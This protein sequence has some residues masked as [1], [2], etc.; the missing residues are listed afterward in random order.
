MS[1]PGGPIRAMSR[2]A[3]IRSVANR[4]AALV[5]PRW[6]AFWH[7]LA[8]T[9]ILALAFWSFIG[10]FTLVTFRSHGISNDEE[11]QHVYGRLLLSFYSSGFTDLSAFTYKNLYLYG[12]LFD[13]FAA[14]IEKVAPFGFWEARHL[15]S[16]CFGIAGMAGAYRIARQIGGEKAGMLAALLLAVTGSWIGAMF[17][18]TK[19]VPF[20]ACMTW[21]L[22]YSMRVAETLPAPPLRLV[23]KLGLT[24]GM[25]IGL[26]VGAV[27]AAFYMALLVGAA[28][29][30][31][32]LSW[33]E[34]IVFVR[35][36]LI[37]LMPAA[38]LAFILMAFFWPWSVMAPTNLFTALTA[39]SHFSFD[40]YTIVDGVV[41]K[42]GDVPS[43]YL[44]QYLLVRLPELLLL[45]V[46]AAAVL[47]PAMLFKLR[48][49]EPADRR[50]A[51]RVIGLLLAIGVPIGFTLAKAPPLYNGIRH[52]LFVVP[53]LAVAAAL[54]LRLLWR[55][56]WQVQFGPVIALALCGGLAL[57]H[58]V[59]MVRLHP[60]QYV[61]Y[62][63]L[64]GGGLEGARGKWELDYWSD[65]IRE[66]AV[67]LNNLVKA[68]GRTVRHPYTVAVCAE[69]L[70]AATYLSPQ[71]RVTA[72]W[73]NADFFISS[74]HMDCHKVL[75][76]DVV[77]RVKREDVTLAVVR[78]RRTLLPL[79]R[80]PRR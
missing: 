18:H 80:P 28:A 12:G 31:A 72:D 62:N 23:L 29:M 2:T 59:D 42:N 47:A 67:D 8:W 9:R 60:Y 25:A 70:Q 78:D 32:P 15:L 77:A 16:A 71:F 22:F 66:A 41:M 19:D 64:F 56:S 43:T 50:A 17:T 33:R 52:F 74:T 79:D 36:S 5:L 24:I 76:G 46:A 48:L 54:G 35:R 40:L 26:R 63:T 38:G 27:F 45:G 55:A 73:T 11:V 14:L 13:F 6:S 34:R 44:S 4:S 65:S 61:A 1:N 3:A 7:S 10:V 39:F 53:P 30:L 75:K 58:T 49:R 57:S 68:E 21:A 20:A 69:P 51:L 37:A